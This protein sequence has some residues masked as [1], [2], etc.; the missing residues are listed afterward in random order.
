[1]IAE[2]ALLLVPDP[3]SFENIPPTRRARHHERHGH[4]SSMVG[5]GWRTVSPNLPEVG[6]GFRQISLRAIPFALRASG[7]P[8]S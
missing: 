1:M 2:Q 3:V 8:V 5:G 7:I 4:R 6:S